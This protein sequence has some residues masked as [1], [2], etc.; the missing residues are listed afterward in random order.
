M[1][2]GISYLCL[3]PSRTSTALYTQP[4]TQNS[5]QY[6]P[7]AVCIHLVQARLYTHSRPHKTRPNMTHVSITLQPTLSPLNRRCRLHLHSWQVGKLIN[8]FGT[9]Q[10]RETHSDDRSHVDKSSSKLLVCL[11]SAKNFPS[12][13]LNLYTQETPDRIAR[14]CSWRETKSY[15]KTG[16]AKEKR[17]R[18]PHI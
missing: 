9:N 15:L 10:L 8:K 17:Y 6:D 16:K 1:V 3:Y 14:A 13:R 18:H 2:F 7:R 4:A 11:F 12:I 5:A